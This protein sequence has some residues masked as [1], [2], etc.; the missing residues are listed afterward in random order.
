MQCQ[1][2]RDELPVGV[3]FCPNCGTPAPVPPFPSQGVAP[4]V[5]ASSPNQPLPGEPA[6]PYAP[7][8][9][10]N[11]GGNVP[12]PPPPGSYAPQ[13]T[14][15]DPSS[16]YGTPGSQFPYGAQQSAPYGAPGTYLPPQQFVPQP[17]QKKSNSYIIALVVGLVV[18]VIIGGIIAAVVSAS[19]N[20]SNTAAS[21]SPTAVATTPASTGGVPNAS[22]VDSTAA[23]MIINHQVS[24]G[25]DSNNQPIDSQTTF[26][27]GA[28]IYVTFETAGQDG[29]ILAKWYIGS[30]HAFDSDLLHDTSGNTI[31]YVSGYFNISGSAVIGL[32]WCTQSDCS[33]AALAQV[34]TATVV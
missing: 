27:T 8:P 6:N 12:P 29:Y 7:P 14:P 15:Y 5:L 18:V 2:C 1:T 25:V 28:T 23:S 13:P 34:A 20:G 31:G 22:Q 10:T 19:H 24:S 11:Y 32:Y 9:P 4:T 30:Q 3:A 16:P 21:A 26:N 33:D 17:P